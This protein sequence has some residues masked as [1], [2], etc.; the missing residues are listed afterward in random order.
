MAEI[1]LTL[2]VFVVGILAVVSA[3]VYMYRLLSDRD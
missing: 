1:V 2:L 3:T